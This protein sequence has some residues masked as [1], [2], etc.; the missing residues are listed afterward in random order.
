[1]VIHP[2]AFTES[3]PSAQPFLA[4]GL[5]AEALVVRRLEEEKGGRQKTEQE[6]SDHS[7]MPSHAAGPG[8][9]RTVR[10]SYVQ[11]HHRDD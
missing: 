5:P 4:R 1:M 8:G 3:S 2:E 9:T 7:L 10:V 11:N 6:E